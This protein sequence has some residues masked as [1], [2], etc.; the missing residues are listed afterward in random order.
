MYISSKPT[1]KE[2][3]KSKKSSYCE[4]RWGWLMKEAQRITLNTDQNDTIRVT[5][6][7]S[8]ILMSMKGDWKIT[9]ITGC[10]CKGFYF[11]FCILQ[12]LWKILPPL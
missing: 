2:K 11:E 10:P 3:C 8:A 1:E 6:N 7:K 9:V 12:A 5:S 4:R